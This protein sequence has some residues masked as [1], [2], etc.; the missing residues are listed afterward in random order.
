MSSKPTLQPPQLKDAAPTQLHNSKDVI[1]R[2]DGGIRLRVFHPLK[3]DIKDCLYKDAAPVK[4]H[5]WS[6]TPG[7][8]D[9]EKLDTASEAEDSRGHDKTCQYRYLS[10]ISDMDP[11][12]PYEC[13]PSKGEGVWIVIM[14]GGFTTRKFAQVGFIC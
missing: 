13:H 4:A 1:S 12:A 3:E 11:G 7:R 5:H 14:D 8:S 6:S 9:A 2:I 10:L